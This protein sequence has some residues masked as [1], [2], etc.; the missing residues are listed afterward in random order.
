MPIS[1][2]TCPPWCSINSCSRRPRRSSSRFVRGE[3]AP[4][5]VTA[6]WKDGLVVRRE[7]DPLTRD[8][9]DELLLAVT[10]CA[11]DQRCRDELWRLTRGNVLFLRQLVEQEL[12]AG[13]MVSTDGVL[14]WQGNL[15]VSGSLAEL[16]DA[17][18][19]AIPD[20][21][22]D[23]VDLVA[24]SEPVDWRC[25]RLIAEQDAIEEA[26]Q[27]KLIGC[28]PTRCTSAIPCLPRCV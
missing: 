8:Q 14:R 26:E 11:P 12:R 28:P 19:G 20:D 10:G 13:R 9:T 25:L 1:S 2:M 18:I 15:G 21:V 6:L 16:V 7:I 17:Q 24:V 27:R 5:A 3:L 22:R 23:V 4:A